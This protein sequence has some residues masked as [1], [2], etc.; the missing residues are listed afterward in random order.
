MVQVETVTLTEYAPTVRLTGDIRAKVESDLSFRVSGRI[1]ERTVDVGDHV[2]ADQVL[3]RLD[4][5]QQ[6]A[7]VTAAEAAVQAAEAV[8]RQATSTYE[9]Q[10]AL[11]TEGLH[12]QT[13]P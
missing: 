3:A 5:Q 12:D 11:L 2:T 10:K 9:R 13:G 8:L 7:T 6:Q 4:P 1:I